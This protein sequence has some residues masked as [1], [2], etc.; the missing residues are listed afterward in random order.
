MHSNFMQN[1]N[2]SEFEPSTITNDIGTN[3]Q[4]PKKFIKNNKEISGIISELKTINSARGNTSQTPNEPHFMYNLPKLDPDQK[5]S[6]N[7]H[8]NYSNINHPKRK[9]SNYSSDLNS[10]QIIELGATMSKYS[11][12]LNRPIT[13]SSILSKKLSAPEL[14]QLFS[15]R[16]ISPS[17]DSDTNLNSHRSTDLSQEKK[18]M[19]RIKLQLD[20]KSEDLRHLRGG[21]DMTSKINQ[22]GLIPKFRSTSY[23]ENKLDFLSIQTQE[24]QENN[25]N[26]LNQPSKA[27]NIDVNDA[28]TKQINIDTI[29]KIRA[30]GDR[31]KNMSMKFARPHLAEINIEPKIR[32]DESARDCLFEFGKN[33]TLFSEILDGGS[34]NSKISSVEYLNEYL[35]AGNN[36]IQR[37]GQSTF[38]NIPTISAKIFN[39]NT[40]NST[41]NLRISS[42]IDNNERGESTPLVLSIKKDLSNLIKSTAHNTRVDVNKLSFLI[43][44]NLK[45]IKLHPNLTEIEKCFK[46][47]EVLNIGLNE[48]IRQISVECNQRANLLY[49]IWSMYLGLFN[50]YKEKMDQEY[51]QRYDEW[52]HQYISIHE[53][54]KDIIDKKSKELNNLNLELEYKDNTIQSVQEKYDELLDKNVKYKGKINHLKKII[55]KLKQSNQQL[56]LE[57][58][59]Y[60]LKSQR[61]RSFLKTNL[62]NGKRYIPS[63][64]LEPKTQDQNQESSNNIV[65]NKSIQMMLTTVALAM[66]SQKTKKPQQ[67]KAKQKND[68]NSSKS[69]NSSSEEEDLLDFNSAKHKKVLNIPTPML[70]HQNN[71]DYNNRSIIYAEM[72]TQIESNFNKQIDV[73][74][75]TNL[76]LIPNKY[77]KL[78]K[79]M[80]TIDDNIAYIDIKEE[81]NIVSTVKRMLPE[82]QKDSFD[83]AFQEKIATEHIFSMILDKIDLNYKSK[84]IPD[85]QSQIFLEEEIKIKRAK[86][87]NYSPSNSFSLESEL[88]KSHE[89]LLTKRNATQYGNLFLFF[90]IKMILHRWT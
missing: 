52:D 74:T 44:D 89:G 15:A 24:N 32:T 64:A 8:N 16:G 45:A 63:I 71:D 90:L 41:K 7:K 38:E 11:S 54:Y 39:N 47:D 57:N 18:A 65:P 28:S 70:I 36:K 88:D 76:Q 78:I 82:D 19:A 81:I 49:R 27:I 2:S 23:A 20:K 83:V 30:I 73:E 22:N 14:K 31:E 67:E 12:T 5:S 46:F 77:N 72:G 62:M 75:Q 86:T 34:K 84:Q 13:F 51:A 42:S 60:I 21:I 4:M 17:Y 59:H 79:D 26:I 80:W 87:R 1:P 50:R 68:Q 61:D 43:E 35:L 33:Q 55:E 37:F 29:K 69:S 53:T 25:R 56:K 58:E 10:D 3:D 48:I 40:K 85:I 66:Q 6:S 9:G